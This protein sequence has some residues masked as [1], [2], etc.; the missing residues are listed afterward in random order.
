MPDPQQGPED[1][2][3]PPVSCRSPLNSPHPKHPPELLAV[4][5][6]GGS[7]LEVSCVRGAEGGFWARDERAPSAGAGD[8]RLNLGYI[9]PHPSEDF[10]KIKKL[11]ARPTCCP[12]Q[13][14]RQHRLK[15]SLPKGW[16]T[17]QEQKIRGEKVFR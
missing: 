3:F 9:C 10:C 4:F 17:G 14:H 12:T 15:V 16:V 2:P 6:Y 7:A 5:R 11:K 8:S 1:S 13:L